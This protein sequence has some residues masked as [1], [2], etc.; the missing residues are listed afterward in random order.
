MSCYGWLQNIPHKIHITNE[1]VHDH[2]KIKSKNDRR[3]SGVKTNEYHILPSKQI[4]NEA[5]AHTHTRVRTHVRMCMR[6][7]CACFPIGYG[8]LDVRFYC[9]YS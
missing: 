5:R 8:G 1:I 9:A 3:R 4:G 2:G 6:V 7:F